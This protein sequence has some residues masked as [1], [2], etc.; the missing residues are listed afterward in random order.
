[1]SLPPDIVVVG[2]GHNGLVCAA[3]L[4]RAG[5]RVTVLEARD[6]VGGCASTVDALGARLNI[7]GCDHVS[8]RATPVMEE[9][10]L[11][12]H[13][14]R[15]L[16]P[17]PCLI[18]IGW[19]QETPLV[20]FGDPDRTLEALALTHPDCVD[21]YARYL[22]VARPA[23]EL[24]L[25]LA[26]QVPTPG[27]VMGRL[28]AR[29]ARGVRTLVAWSRRSATSVLRSMFPHEDLVAAAAVTGPAVWGLP[30]SAPGTGL[31]ALTY[32][33]RHVAPVGRPAGGSGML[34]AALTGALEAA[35]GSVRTAARVAT[36][37]ADGDRVRGVVLE[38][39]E[40]IE[41]T[42]GVVVACDARRAIVS[43]LRDPP[44]VAQDMVQR[45]RRTRVRD[46]YESKLDAVVSGPAPRLPLADGL[47]EKLIDRTGLADLA[48]ASTVVHPGVDGLERN[49]WELGP[50]RVARR[51]ALLL[52]VPS[53][54]DPVLRTSPG[55]HVV[56]MEVLW[57]PYALDGGWEH[58]REP[59]RWLGFLDQVF[60]AGTVGRV[61]RWRA[62]TPPDYERQF[63]LV[64]GYA[65]SYR[66]GPLAALRARDPERSRYRTP[67]RGLFLTGA[68]TFPGAG[69]WG[70]SGRNAASVV[71]AA[72]GAGVRVA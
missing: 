72:V 29:R 47:V 41:A 44:A 4:A 52:S 30:P 10:G 45:W 51:P 13:G 1:M 7:C 39:G 15:Y 23:A 2:A 68:D 8:F 56:S 65:P 6:Q 58:S 38:D 55:E 67:L 48:G 53:A 59:E 43:W 66:G 57:T 12:E 70:A 28:L 63:G 54:L 9:L 33:M 25:D 14:L 71:L 17:D 50:G 46:G 11:A 27:K 3:Y 34:P 31:A 32:A 62:L 24:L 61:Q 69:I 22:R 35:G 19:D 21:P 18:G 49:H 26:N 20:Q 60:G 36:V 5:L 40:E 37:L 42:E 64:R 16:E